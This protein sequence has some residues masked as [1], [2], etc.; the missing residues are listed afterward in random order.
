MC[1]CVYCVSE[2]SYLYTCGCIQEP[3]R[4]AGDIIIVLDEK[5]HDFYTRKGSDLKINMVSSILHMYTYV[6]VHLYYI[7]TLLFMYTYSSRIK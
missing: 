2:C 6:Y 4:E 5:E 3:G 7:S 1:V